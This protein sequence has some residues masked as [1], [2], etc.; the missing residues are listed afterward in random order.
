MAKKI[1]LQQKL[2]RAAVWS[3]AAFLVP[4]VVAYQ[5]ELYLVAFLVLAVIVFSLLFHVSKEREYVFTDMTFAS[6]LVIA[7]LYLV[8]QAGFTHVLSFMAFLAALI[9]L[10]YYYASWKGH[11]GEGMT[12]GIY[13]QKHGLW[14]A[15]AALV[16][17][18]AILASVFG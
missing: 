1:T 4:M 10:F 7:N 2:Q 3:N 9:A 12:D 6:F 14:H 18:L 13:N 5:Y 17:L 8:I 15:F 11:M 16:T